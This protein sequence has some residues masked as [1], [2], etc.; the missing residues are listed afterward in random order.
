MVDKRL[1]ALV[2]QAKKEIAKTVAA[3]YIGLIATICFSATLAYVLA[4]MLA[5]TSIAVY[6]CLG[7]CAVAIILKCA[8]SYAIE[9][10]SFN[11]AR[12]IKFVLRSK[13]YEKLAR[14]DVAS[15]QNISTAELIQTTV[16]GTEQLEIYFGKFCRNLCMRV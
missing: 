6:A 10:Y 16:E 11:A 7:V 15:A 2:P 4:A 12:D 13:I 9:L 1:L 3:Q 8:S 5:H 14:L